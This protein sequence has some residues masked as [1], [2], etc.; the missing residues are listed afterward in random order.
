MAV[1]SFAAAAPISQP[2]LDDQM[3]LVHWLPLEADGTPGAI[4]SGVAAPVTTVAPGTAVTLD[5]S[6][7]PSG[8][9]VNVKGI[10]GQA[11]TEVV[12]VTYTNADGS[13]AT[14]SVTFEQTLDPAELDVAGFSATID[15]PV[16]QTPT[17]A[18]TSRRP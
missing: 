6:A 8:L 10:K 16:A 3:A 5:G 14:G 17:P 1:K 9:S 7:D 12:T 11:G 18:A 15:T 13:V 4:P 2:M